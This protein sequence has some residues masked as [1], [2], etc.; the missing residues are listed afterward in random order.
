[1]NISGGLNNVYF[2]TAGSVCATGGTSLQ[3]PAVVLYHFR[4]FFASSVVFYKNPAKT[5]CLLSYNE[6]LIVVSYY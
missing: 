6:V 2:S 4:H 3:M 1:M 5:K